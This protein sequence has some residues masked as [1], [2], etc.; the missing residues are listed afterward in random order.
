MVVFSY[1]SLLPAGLYGFLW[2]AGTAGTTTV[3]SF[4][5]LVCLYGYSLTIYIP[6]SLLWLVQVS[7]WQ[8]LCVLAGAG[9][10]GYVLF[11]PIYPAVRHQTARAALIVMAVIV[12][13]HLLLA[14]GFMLYF[15]HV[16]AVAAGGNIKPVNSTV[17]VP[18]QRVEP[19]VVADSQTGGEIKQ[20]VKSDE[21]TEITQDDGKAGDGPGPNDDQTD[22]KDLTDPEISKLDK[23][24][25]KT[26]DSIEG[27]E[28]LSGK[29]S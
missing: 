24:E 21:G 3:I 9:L 10:S 22:K 13:L 14:V 20:E 29:E 15:F 17:I 18:E 12:T 23:E 5:E 25:T 27:K 26:G 28:G 6:V 8:W 2:W 1:A 7:W 11:L 16:P 19:G 4:L